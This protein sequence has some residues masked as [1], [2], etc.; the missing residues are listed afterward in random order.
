[1]WYTYL[2]HQCQSSNYAAQE[3]D[4]KPRNAKAWPPW[5]FIAACCR[6]LVGVRLHAP[7]STR[8]R[9]KKA[10]PMTREWWNSL[11]RGQGNLSEPGKTSGADCSKERPNDLCLFR[12]YCH[13][14]GVLS[15]RWPRKGFGWLL[16]RIS[17]RSSAP[18]AAII[19]SSS[20][21]QATVTLASESRRA[22]RSPTAAPA[23]WALRKRSG[24]PALLRRRAMGRRFSGWWPKLRVHF[25][26]AHSPYSHFSTSSNNL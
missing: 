8:P 14:T 6:R 21:A 7:H 4:D 5:P 26:G 25:A 20:F 3:P 11:N 16:C 15:A 2:R 24:L 18:S 10:P 9:M 13:D 23:G 1:M 12:W 19:T 17:K 22:P